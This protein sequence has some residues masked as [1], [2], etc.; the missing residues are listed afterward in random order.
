MRRAGL[1]ALL[2]LGA[3][4][5]PAHAAYDP[6]FS[7]TVDPATPSSPTA[8][9]GTVT[10]ASGE[11][12]TREQRVRYPPS[13][14]FNPGFDVQPCTRAAED[15]QACPESSAIG[16]ASAQTTFGEFSGPVHLTEDYR[17]VIFL[18]GFAGLVQAQKVE[19]RLELHPDGSVETVI[20]DLPDVQSTQ[21]RV[22]LLGGSK[23]LVLTPRTCGE[24]VVRAVFTSHRDE[25]AE[26]TASIAIS[27]CDTHPRF[28]VAAADPAR[29][30]RRT[31]RTTLV[32]RLDDAGQ[33][34]V[35]SIR[36]VVRSG[37]FDRLREVLSQRAGASDGL[38]RAA[39]ALRQGGKALPAGDSVAHRTARSAQGRT[40]DAITVRF[41]IVR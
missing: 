30:R 13:F 11:S 35:V 19:G 12:A 26:R 27:G 33:A 9:T 40:T 34:T 22:A 28:V 18:R 16:T 20:R 5:P 38:N 29:V 32:W 31:A 24:H 39:V 1:A 41:R 37:R 23:S 15:A 17:L 10:Q 4:A 6:R 3:L 7:M 25:V 21:A 36:R 14:G 2:A 8:V